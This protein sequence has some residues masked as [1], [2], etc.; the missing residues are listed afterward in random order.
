[1]TEYKHV[2]YEVRGAIAHVRL[3]RVKYRNAQS[4]L[5]L[6]EMDAAFQTAADDDTVRVIVL[7]GKGEHFSSG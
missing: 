5:M 2:E 7:S 6:D 4:H 3:N 1:M